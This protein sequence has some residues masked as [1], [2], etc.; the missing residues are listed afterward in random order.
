MIAHGGAKPPPVA[1]VVAF[2]DGDTL[3]VPVRLEV[4][5]PPSLS[6]IEP[7]TPQILYFGHGAPST[8]SARDLV[9]EARTRP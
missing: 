6:Q 4:V 7:L 1:G 8:A 5:H 2:D 9:A 3:D